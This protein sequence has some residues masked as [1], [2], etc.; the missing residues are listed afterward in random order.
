MSLY[1]QLHDR[2]DSAL[3]ELR[4]SL[5]AMSRLAKRDILSNDPTVVTF[6][7]LVANVIATVDGLIANLNTVHTDDNEETQDQA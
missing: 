7:R 5:T 4:T 2:C 3:P 6:V 1:W